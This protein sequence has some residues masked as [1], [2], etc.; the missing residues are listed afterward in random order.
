MKEFKID[1][2]R[3]QDRGFPPVGGHKSKAGRVEKR[4]NREG[5][6]GVRQVGTARAPIILKLNHKEVLIHDV[7]AVARGLNACQQKHVF[8]ADSHL[9]TLLLLEF[10]DIVFDSGQI[11]SHL[12]LETSLSSFGTHLLIES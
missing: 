10:G 4:H 2:E 12:S 7:A 1:V 3:T 5:H 6:A 11:E 8:R 9:N